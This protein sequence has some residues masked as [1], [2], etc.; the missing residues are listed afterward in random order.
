MTGY[1]RAQEA[2]EVAIVTNPTRTRDGLPAAAVQPD[3]HL[4]PPSAP[5]MCDPAASRDSPRAT[6]R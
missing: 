6:R 4:A 3:G 2:Q 5:V 1:S